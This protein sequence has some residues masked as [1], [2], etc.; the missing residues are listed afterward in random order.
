M[1]ILD[2]TSRSSINPISLVTH[3]AIE[4]GFYRFARNTCERNPVML[5]LNFH[6][7]FLPVHC[8]MV[9]RLTII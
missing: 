8:Y 5:I 1:P 9:I 6:G 4:D 3:P 2:S 7:S